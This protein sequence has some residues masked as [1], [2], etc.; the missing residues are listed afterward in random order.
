VVV[1]VGVIE[2]DLRVGDAVFGLDDRVVNLGDANE[3]DAVSGADYE[4][5]GFAE[6]VGES[7]ARGEVVGL[8]GDFAGRGKQRV[9]EESGGGEGLQVPADA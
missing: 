5:T 9:G 7:G 1:V 4:R 6:G 3:E 8:E 2:E